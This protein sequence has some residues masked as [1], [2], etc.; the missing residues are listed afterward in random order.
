MKHLV[1]MIAIAGFSAFSVSCG[2]NQEE[3][4]YLVDEFAD[5]KIMRYQV[6]GWDGLTLQQK[7]Y[8]FHLAE[9]A[10]YGRDIIWVQNCRYNLQVRKMLENILENYTGDRTTEEF[11]QFEEYAKRV[12]FSNGVH[13]HYAE[14]KFFPVCSRNYF[15]EL[16]KAVD[17]YDLRLLT[18]IYDYDACP[19]RKS[20]DKSKDI[21]V[22]SAVNFYEGV[23][24]AEAEKFYADMV[25][26]ADKTPVSYGL[27]S[28]LVKGE[29]GTIL[30][31]ETYHYG[32]EIV[33]PVAPTKAA[34]NTYTYTFAGW[35]KEVV[36]C[37]GNA[38]YTAT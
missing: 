34:D 4:R 5:L 17:A 27:N 3:F 13:H 10:K 6:P 19:Q 20:T 24:K 38:T 30:S 16:M 35:D 14:D 9:A 18:F 22:A 1:K 36:N 11:L 32:D 23:S 31:T 25:D 26:P 8:V 12:F 21:V 28:R 2:N 7:E 33:V 29:D 15:A 37:A